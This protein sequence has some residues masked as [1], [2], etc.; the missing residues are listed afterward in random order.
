MKINVKIRDFD[1]LYTLI[2]LLLVLV[3][4][5]GI[6]AHQKAEITALEHRNATQ[7]E[8]IREQQDYIN[9]FETTDWEHEI[10]VMNEATQD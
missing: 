2:A 6:I 7:A 10:E 5:C 1:V 3:V 8:R 9:D 4:M